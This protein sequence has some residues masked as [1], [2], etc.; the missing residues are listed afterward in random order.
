MLWGSILF[1]SLLSA[2]ILFGSAH[3]FT[4]RTNHLCRS[5]R[6][7]LEISR[8]RV[9]KEKIRKMDHTGVLLLILAHS[10]ARISDGVCGGACFNVVTVS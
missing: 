5:F 3:L 7:N 8:R 4:D 1:V 9:E 6:V 10:C 2:I